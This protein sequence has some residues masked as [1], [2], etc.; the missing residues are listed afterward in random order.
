[1]NE[2]INDKLKS[3]IYSSPTIKIAILNHLLGYE[4]PHYSARKRMEM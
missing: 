2:N 3:F 4:S 1:M